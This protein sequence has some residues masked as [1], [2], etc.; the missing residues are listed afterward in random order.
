MRFIDFLNSKQG[1]HA[2]RNHCF[3]LNGVVLGHFTKMVS[4]VLCLIIW[5]PKKIYFSRK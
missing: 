2:A 1:L 3:E 4:S 5:V